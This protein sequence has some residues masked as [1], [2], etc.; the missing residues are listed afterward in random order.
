MALVANVYDLPVGLGRSDLYAMDPKQLGAA[1]KHISRVTHIKLEPGATHLSVHVSAPALTLN[2]FGIRRQGEGPVVR[3]V[4]EHQ[5]CLVAGDVLYLLVDTQGQGC[6]PLTV[7]RHGATLTSVEDVRD[8][9]TSRKRP[10][11]ALSAADCGAADRPLL[12]SPPS[13]SSFSCSSSSSSSSTSPPISYHRAMD[14]ASL[15]VRFARPAN[16]ILDLLVVRDIGCLDCT[17]RAFHGDRGGSMGSVSSGGSSGGSGG[18]SGGRPSV[19]EAA[20]WKS[21]GEGEAEDDPLCMPAGLSPRMSATQWLLRRRDVREK[22]EMFLYPIL[23]FVQGLSTSGG[24]GSSGS[25][26]S[27]SS[28]LSSSSSSMSSSSSSS[29]SS[30]VGGRWGSAEGTSSSEQTHVP[31]ALMSANIPTG[32][33]FNS[34]T[35]NGDQILSK[36][37]RSSARWA[38][39]VKNISCILANADVVAL[40]ETIDDVSEYAGAQYDGMYVRKLVDGINTVVKERA[41]RARGRAGS[42]VSQVSRIGG[43]AAGGARAGGGVATY[44]AKVEALETAETIKHYAYVN[45]NGGPVVYNENRLAP[46]FF[47]RFLISPEPGFDHWQVPCTCGKRAQWVSACNCGSTDEQGETVPG[48]PAW[49][50]GLGSVVGFRFHR[51]S[52]RE[53]GSMGND[54][55]GAGGGNGGTAG[56]NAGTRPDFVVINVHVSHR[57]PQFRLLGARTVLAPLVAVLRERHGCP[58]FLLGD[59]NYTKVR[60]SIEQALIGT[61]KRAMGSIIVTNCIGLTALLNE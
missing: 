6:Y 51:P 16:L 27:S 60:Q 7:R 61:R 58:V 15:V 30:A 3:V 55:K 9:A 23:R 48:Y 28:R 10:R 52:R 42:R 22:D 29:S 33:A 20:L 39:Q 18:G 50:S 40:Q 46:V 17:A 32:V 21:E 34:F 41:E 12:P 8:R 38:A 4:G 19:I 31:L 45:G 24:V 43:G 56:G 25:S 2:R 49:K 47:N 11:D 36:V 1:A 13:A 5:V 53:G 37:E 44:G 35:D 14:L 57:N 59:F 26:S 54:G